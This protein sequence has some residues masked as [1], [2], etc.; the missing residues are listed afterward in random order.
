MNRIDYPNIVEDYW[1][2]V[3]RYI[4]SEGEIIQELFEEDYY[5]IVR[6]T[7]DNIYTCF[8]WME[9]GN[10]KITR[11]VKEKKTSQRGYSY[12]KVVRK[13]AIRNCMELDCIRKKYFTLPDYFYKNR[14]HI[15][16]Y[17]AFAAR[18][19]DGILEYIKKGRFE[20]SEQVCQIFKNTAE[21]LGW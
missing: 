3:E 16:L 13:T 21:R 2:A 8:I 9:G 11:I 6:K 1:E 15:R 10:P 17:G 5:G 7:D 18:Y 19:R 20:L 12:Y 14:E 4:Y